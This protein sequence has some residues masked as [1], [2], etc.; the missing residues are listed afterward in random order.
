MSA[1]DNIRIIRRIYEQVFDKHNLGVVDEFYTADYVYHG[2]GFPEFDREGLKNSF[3]E[4]LAAFPDVHMSVEDIFAAGDRVASR[5]VCRGTHQG[6]FMGIPPTGKQVTGTAI[7][8]QRLVD[9]KVAE[10]WEWSDGL[11]FMQQL[12]L[13]LGMEQKTTEQQFKDYLSHIVE[14]LNARDW[15]ALDR[16]VDAS[17]ASDYVLHFPGTPDMHGP[18]EFKQFFHGIVESFPDYRGTIEDAFVVGDK[19]AARFMGHR[20]DQDTGKEQHI[21]GLL[22]SHLK[23]GK[24]NEDWEIVGDWEDEA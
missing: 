2:P 1:E 10:D 21:A 20:T 16:L 14:A 17:V 7:L 18:E 15:R 19:A 3:A 12:G 9:G 6:V 22:I 4:F 24:Y 5:Y 23:D 11:G 8:I 13:V